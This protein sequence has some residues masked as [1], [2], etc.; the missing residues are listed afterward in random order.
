VS[1][2]LLVRKMEIDV[3]KFKEDGF[4]HLSGFFGADEVE[5]IRRAAMR[6]F[7]AQ[8]LRHRIVDSLD[9]PEREFED[10]M[11]ELFRRFPQDLVNCGKQAQHLISLHRLS[12]HPRVEATLRDLG[13]GF[14]NISTRPVLFFNSRHLAEREVYWKVFPHQDWRSMQGSLDAIVLWLPLSDIDVPLGALEIVPGSHTLGLV[15]T[16]VVDGFGRV[17]QFSD[18][19]FVPMSCRQG[20]A[21]FLSSFLVHRSGNN[22]TESIRWSCHFRYNNLDER[23]FIERG[24]PHPYLYKP[25]EEL[26]TRDFPSGELIREIY[27]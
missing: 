8:I 24:Y 11:F 1:D 5:E 7:L 17:E 16:E 14:P 10:G 2:G 23:T 4:V 15:T 18:D 27:S 21:L 9:I 25:Q 12:L 26:I 19:D 6:V 3:A 20:D 22:V 13:L